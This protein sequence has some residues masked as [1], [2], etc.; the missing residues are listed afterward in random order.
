MPRPFQCQC[1]SATRQ[2]PE[3]SLPTWN[4]PWVDTT[5]ERREKTPLLDRKREKEMV[6]EVFRSW[7][8]RV[9]AD[10]HEGKV[11]RPEMMTGTRQ[12]PSQHPPGL[13]WRT[14]R[15]RILG[16]AEYPEE[17]VLRHGTRRPATRHRFMLKESKGGRFVG[18]PCITQRDQHARIQK[19]DHGSSG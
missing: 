16:M 9:T 10:V 18:V 8:I 17:R 15:P 3:R 1:F 14:K 11:V 2:D 12:K 19:G 7:Q 13:R 6:S 4:H 5:I